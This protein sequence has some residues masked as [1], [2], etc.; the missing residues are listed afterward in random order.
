[1]DD[2]RRVI[3]SVGCD[4]RAADDCHTEHTFEYRVPVETTAGHAIIIGCA[5]LTDLGW[6][7]FSDSW[8]CPA[9]WAATAAALEAATLD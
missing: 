6:R 3:L 1:M 9:C 5:Q 8:Y 7:H 2:T 4:Y